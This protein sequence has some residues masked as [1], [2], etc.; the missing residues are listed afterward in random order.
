MYSEG[1]YGEGGRNVIVNVVK[2]F[3][4]C[5]VNEIKVK[6]NDYKRI[7]DD[8]FKIFYV[9]IIFLFLKFYVINDVLKEFYE[10]IEV[11]FYIFIG[12]EVFGMCKDIII[13]RLKLE[14]IIFLFL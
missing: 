1:M 10:I 2:E 6:E 3:K 12:F 9:I 4:I 8:F 11:W 5:V 13:E 7:W 14:G